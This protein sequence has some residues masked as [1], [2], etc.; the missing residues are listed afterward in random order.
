MFV[1]SSKHVLVKCNNNA[2]VQ[3][4]RSGKRR[5]PF[6]ATCARNVWLVAAQADIDITYIHIP[7][8]KNTVADL[9]SHWQNRPQ[10]NTLLN[11]LVQS[12]MWLEMSMS[13]L[14]MDNDI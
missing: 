13:L 4:L 10:Q 2:V 9:L 1:Q 3:V 12:P 14:E 8:K 11:S 5:D 7:G 6:L